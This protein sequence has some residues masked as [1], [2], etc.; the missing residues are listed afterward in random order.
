VVSEASRLQALTETGLPHPNPAVVSA[1]LFVSCGF[2]SGCG[3]GPGQIRDAAPACGRRATGD[4][5]REGARVFPC[6]VL[7]GAGLVSRARAARRAAYGGTAR[8]PAMP[9]VVAT[10]VLPVPGG[11]RK[12]TFSFAVTKSRVPRW[13]MASRLSP[14]A[15]SKSNFS[16]DLRAGNRA[17]RMRPSPPWAS[18][19]EISRCRQAM[20][21][22]SWLQFS[23]RARSASRPSGSRSVGAFN[24]RVRN[25]TSAVR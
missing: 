3:Q 6:R 14:R 12:T 2:L 7:P 1:P 23:D 13:A 4:R 25:V 9:V 10:W 21:N 16:N 19:A 22:S 5:G 18:R 24:A 20:R 8:G 17:A 11:P 15:W